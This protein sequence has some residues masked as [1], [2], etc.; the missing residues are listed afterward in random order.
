MQE[1]YA[2]YPILLVE[3]NDSDAILIKRAL[4]QLNTPNPLV[5]FQ[6]GEQAIN[7]FKNAPEIKAEMEYALPILII[8]DL[9][10]PKK[11]GFEV[12]Q[13]IKNTNVIKRIPVIILTSSSEY[14]EINKAY[15]FGANSY[16]KKPVAFEDLIYIMKILSIYWLKLNSQPEVNL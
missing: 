7:Y 11:S 9:K 2:N 5:I 10:L 6:D 14:T 15:D 3:D 16:I 12:L 4:K 13:Y 1:S 8:L